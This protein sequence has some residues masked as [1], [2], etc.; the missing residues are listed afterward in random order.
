MQAKKAVCVINTKGGTGKT[1]ISL[2]LG[3]RLTK[4][5]KVALLDVDLDNSSFSQFTGIDG[6]IKV[7]KEQKF[8]PFMW[9]GMEVFSMSL[10]TARDQ[11]VSMT[12]DRYV[13]IID[14]VITRSKWN[15]EFMVFDMP[16]GSSD[17]FR[18]VISVL[19]DILVGNII[20]HQPAMVDSTRKILGLHEYLE[21]P[22]LGIIE[23]MSY[24][25]TGYDDIYR[26]L[27]NEFAKQMKEARTKNATENLKALHDRVMNELDWMKESSVLHP[28]GPSTV[29]EIAKE[30]GVPVLGKIPLVPTLA[31]HF[32]EGNPFLEE[33]YL[34]PI[35]NA[36]KIFLESNVQKPGFLTKMKEKVV[37]A[38]KSEVIK[39]MAGLLMT[40]NRT[41]NVKDLRSKTGF[42]QDRPFLL[43]ITDKSENELERIGLQ[44][45]EQGVML[46]KDRTKT[47]EEYA[48]WIQKTFEFQIVGDYQTIA[49][50]VMGKRK[51]GGVEQP[52]STMAAWLNG[53]LKAY[54]LGYA[55]RAVNAIRSIF[56]NEGV[57]GPVREEYGKVLMRWI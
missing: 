7:D 38:V 17:I 25:K 53:D 36:I 56:E 51:I 3:K 1:L 46:L 45:T 52:F 15:A 6:V 30:Y 44:V 16:G 49:R 12:G 14:D 28:F 18:S 10:V 9:Q 13:Q 54:G 37:D 40:V 43:I 4:F 27:R 42:T 2:N 39:V 26:F 31:Q 47:P 22:V 32:K 57:I 8:E 50:I 29:D 34:E 55:P 23:N 48:E 20:I 5:G 24:F 21:I 35:D 41:F 19:G 33:Q 11:S